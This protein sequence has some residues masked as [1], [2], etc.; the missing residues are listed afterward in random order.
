MARKEDAELNDEYEGIA[1]RAL[2]NAESA[3]TVSRGDE[4]IAD[5][6]RAQALA[7]VEIAKAATGLV[8][9][10]NTKEDRHG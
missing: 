5:R 7:Y 6:Y 1:R 4:K 10:T 9:V 3:M 8:A 2:Q